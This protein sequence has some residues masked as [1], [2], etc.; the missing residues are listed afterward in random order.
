MSDGREHA[1]A[2]SV[3]AGADAGMPA[4]EE[5][6]VIPVLVTRTGDSSQET[7]NFIIG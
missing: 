1:L 6:S 2:G 4:L 5:A 7:Q 3:A